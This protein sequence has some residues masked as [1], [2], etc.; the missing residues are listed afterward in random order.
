MFP[1]INWNFQ[2]IMIINN[3]IFCHS[4]QYLNNLAKIR[5]IIVTAKHLRNYL[6]IKQEKAPAVITTAEA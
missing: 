6:A 5:L 1:I 3:S 2:S 4:S